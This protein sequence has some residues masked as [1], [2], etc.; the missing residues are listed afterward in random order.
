M[1]SSCPKHIQIQ[2]IQVNN[3]GDL[4]SNL[5]STPGGTLFSTTPGG[6]RIV[7]DRSF[8]MQCRNSPLAKNPPNLPKIPGVTSSLEETTAKSAK[9]EE[10]KPNQGEKPASPL[11]TTDEPQFDMDL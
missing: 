5:S 4:P 1:S 2:R 8:L 10:P 9:K 11:G 7:Y 3:F 6:T